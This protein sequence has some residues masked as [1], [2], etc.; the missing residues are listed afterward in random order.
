MYVLFAVFNQS[1]PGKFSHKGHADEGHG[2]GEVR[3]RKHFKRKENKMG[4]KSKQNPMLV[5]GKKS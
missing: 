3:R 5:E 1:P 2:E 4:K